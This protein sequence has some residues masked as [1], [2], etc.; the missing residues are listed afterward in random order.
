MAWLATADEQ[1]KKIIASFR[2]QR[3]RWFEAYTPQDETVQTLEALA[4]TG[5][6]ELEL[7]PKLSV[8]L[9]I[10]EVRDAVHEFKILSDHYH[11]YWPH[12]GLCPTGLSG[13]PEKIAR[14]ALS[15]LNAWASRID[16]VLAETAALQREADDLALLREYVTG[17][18]ESA[19][20]LF[21]LAH[22]SG[23]LSKCIFCCPREQ[24]LDVR[25]R[26]VMKG[27]FPRAAHRFFVVIG[28]PE[29]ISEIEKITAAHSCQ[30]IAIPEW[31]PQHTPEQQARIDTRLEVFADGLKVLHQ[32]A[33]T[34]RLCA[35]PS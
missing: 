13:P 8:P 18:D 19:P 2:P 32:R 35:G 4:K 31:L 5:T 28:L 1:L 26:D 30:R 6:V 22:P 9:D 25:F 29:R 14:T 12:Y 33:E 21:T 11:N 7:D 15:H 3:A 10:A 23:L 17:S 24:M 16:P 27:E 20:N 34:L